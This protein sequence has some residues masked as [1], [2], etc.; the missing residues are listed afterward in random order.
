MRAWGEEKKVGQKRNASVPCTAHQI[1]N[2]KGGRWPVVL[3]GEQ[4][5]G[6]YGG[7]RRVPKLS[8]A[9]LP[10]GLL[11]EFQTSLFVKRKLDKSGR[12]SGI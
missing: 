5:C 12:G 11:A 6:N 2:W 4:G 1:Q 3:Q 8:G 9:H 10:Q 7:F